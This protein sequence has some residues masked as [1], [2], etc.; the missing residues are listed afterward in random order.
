MACGNGSHR[1]P[2]PCLT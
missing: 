2:H 1:D